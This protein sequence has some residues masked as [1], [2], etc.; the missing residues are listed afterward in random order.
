MANMTNTLTDLKELLL[1]GIR[2]SQQGSYS[3]RQPSRDALPFLEDART[4]LV[5]FVTA[6]PNNAEAWRL[7]SQAQ[8]CLLRYKDA[9]ASFT[10]A[11]TIEGKR[12]KKD[13][14]RLALLK[15]SAST[16]EALPLSSSDLQELGEFLVAERAN[17]ESKG[18]S[19]EITQRWLSIKGH[20]N[21]EHVIEAL[22]ARGGY[23]DFQVLY[24][25]VR[26]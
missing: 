13:L 17:E 23:T 5:D 21:P 10:R 24:N 8:E 22:K 3:R 26:G 18:R 12:D 16:W 4:R 19:L 9:I 6:N 7:L 1:Q 2:K 11:I 15:E 20:N 25:V 14:K